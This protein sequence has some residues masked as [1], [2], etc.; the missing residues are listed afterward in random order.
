MSHPRLSIALAV[1]TVPLAACSSGGTTEGASQ[2]TGGGATGAGTTGVGTTGA[3]GRRSG[4]R[5]HGNGR[6]HYRNRRPP[7]SSAT[8]PAPAATTPT[9]SPI[10]AICTC[11]PRTRS[12]PTRSAPASDPQNAYLFAKGQ[13][14]GPRR[15]WHQR[16]PRGPDITQA[17]PLDFLAVTDHSEWL[18]VTPRL[19]RR[20]EQRL[21]RYE[22]LRPWSGARRRRPTRPPC[23][24]GSGPSRR[25]SAP[26]IRPAASRRRNR[27]WQDLIAAAA[28]AYAPCQ[29]TSL[30]AYEWTELAAGGR[31]RHQEDDWGHQTIAT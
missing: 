17:R 31:Q 4:R 1:L 8:A 20:S 25:R 22:R 16:R 6:R 10:S 11:T 15:D 24:P 26:G 13:G 9:S 19:H 7:R 30:I 27:P 23:S 14:R 29:F 28:A 18:M 12:T 3:G 21:L 5:H 2:G